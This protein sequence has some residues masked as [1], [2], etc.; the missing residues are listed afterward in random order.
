MVVL[1]IRLDLTRG[2]LFELRN[3][4][5]LFTSVTSCSWY[6]YSNSIQNYFLE[7][8]KGPDSKPSMLTIIQNIHVSE[9]FIKLYEMIEICILT[10]IWTFTA[11]LAQA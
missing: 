6:R 8:L 9:T 11:V 7:Q 3:T 2:C 5:D 1:Q 10:C 4:Y